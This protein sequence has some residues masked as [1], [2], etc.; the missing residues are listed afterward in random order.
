M[1]PG[2]GKTREAGVANMSACIILQL[3]QLVLAEGLVVC[4][5]CGLY[6]QKRL[7]SVGMQSKS[8]HA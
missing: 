5:P 8:V 7:A 3:Q 1:L 4:K 2:A 6:I